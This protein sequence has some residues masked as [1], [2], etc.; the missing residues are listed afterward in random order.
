MHTLMLVNSTSCDTGSLSPPV[1]AGTKVGGNPA[2]MTAEGDGSSH[3]SR[4][5]PTITT[6]TSTAGFTVRK[7]PYPNHPLTTGTTVGI[8]IDLLVPVPLNGTRS[9]EVLGSVHVM[10]HLSS[11]P[12]CT[13]MV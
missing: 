9:C 6:F 13:S 3:A 1:R 7:K 10:A 11:T 8:H 4:G 2:E 5:A 12:S